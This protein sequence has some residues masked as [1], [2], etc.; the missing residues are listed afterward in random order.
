[1][2]LEITE[3]NSEVCKLLILSNLKSLRFYQ[4]ERE[5]LWLF[6][7]QWCSSPCYRLLQIAYIINIVYDSARC[8]PVLFTDSYSGLMIANRDT[9]GAKGYKYPNI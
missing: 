9:L 3:F 2:F 4:L 6:K 8:W 7:R 1:M 5:G